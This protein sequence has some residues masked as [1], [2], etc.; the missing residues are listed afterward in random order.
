MLKIPWPSLEPSYSDSKCRTIST[1][2][3]CHGPS[4]V[5][6][7]PEVAWGSK[8][9]LVLLLYSLCI[10]D[11]QP[12]ALL[13]DLPRSS[14]NV[15]VRHRVPKDLKNRTLKT[16][17]G[18]ERTAEEAWLVLFSAMTKSFSLKKKKK[19]SSHSLWRYDLHQ[20]TEAKS[21][22]NLV[23]CLWSWNEPVEE[24]KFPSA[25]F[26]SL[27]FESQ[28][29]TYDIAVSFYLFNY[30]QTHFPKDSKWFAIW[31]DTTS[32]DKIETSKGNQGWEKHKYKK[33]SPR[34]ATLLVR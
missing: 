22:V 14:K 15:L 9:C 27:W 25:S 19:P 21:N 34:K 12:V 32:K 24:R 4:S 13:I 33:S 8:L 28:S 20:L 23:T 31:I 29:P 6:Y 18:L 26:Q 17:L 1:A 2:V 5:P 11:I 7:W 16:L 10:P 3:I 30:I